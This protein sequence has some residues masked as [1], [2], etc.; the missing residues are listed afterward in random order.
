MKRRVLKSVLAC[1]LTLSLL[2]ACG[3]QQAEAPQ[4]KVEN[5]NGVAPQQNNQQSTDIALQSYEDTFT[6]RDL[7]QVAD[8]DAA[9]YVELS[10]E[11]ISIDGRGAQAEGKVVTFT[12]EG[13]YVISGSL[14]GG[15]LVVDAAKEDKVQLVLEGVSVTNDSSAA[16]YVKQADKVFVTTGAGTDNSF[17]TTGEFVDI[18][19]NTIDGAVFSKDDII[20]NGEGSLNIIC[21]ADHGIVGKDDIKVTGGSIVVDAKGDGLQAND[22]IYI[23][24]GTVSVLNSY[25]GMEAQNI[26][27]W[28]GDITIIAEDDGLNGAGGND[29]SGLQ[30]FGGNNPF[31]ADLSCNVVIHGGALHVSADGDGLDSN[32]NLVINGGEIYV[33]GPTNGGNGAIDFGGSGIMNGGVL[34]AT[35]ADGMAE[36]MSQG[37]GQCTMMVTLSNQMLEGELVVKDA[38]GNVILSH[39]PEKRYNNAVISHPDLKVGE[40][41]TVS[42]GEASAEVTFESTIYGQG[43]MN[44]GQ[45]GFG[46]GHGGFDGNKG[47]GSFGGG[48]ENGGQGGRGERPEMGE[49]PE[50]MELPE[51]MTPPEGMEMPEGMTPPEGMEMPEGMTPPEGMENM[52]QM[53]GV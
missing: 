18:D 48:K 24:D 36:N 49:M 33:N 41:Y 45:G 23:A 44:G 51:G 15:Q 53:P 1:A 25:E 37:S 3:G 40:T 11:G 46:G 32:G 7:R 35:G 19:E 6:E 12:D 39:T 43:M 42:V 29:G 9:I 17:E 4:D 50:G 20:F 28:N 22:G 21:N 38:A 27:V 2:T 26:Y 52:P 47:D 16:L 31:E 10:E 34:V 13:T 30:S 5:G 8:L 14:S